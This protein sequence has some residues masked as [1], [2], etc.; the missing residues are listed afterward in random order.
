MRIIS[1]F[2]ILILIGCG[3]VSSPALTPNQP[4]ATS[5]VTATPI[6]PTVTATAT[7][8]PDVY[9]T[10]FWVTSTAIV[11]SILTAEPGRVYRSYASPDQK[12]TAEIRIYDCVRV[13][14]TTDADANAYEQLNLIENSSNI[15]RSADGQ[16]QNCGGVGAVG[17]EGLYWSSNNQYFYY[18]DA[19]RGVPD[20]SCGYWE[21]PVLRLDVGALKI[22][23]L[24]GG[25]VSPDRTKIATWQGKE[26]VVWDINMGTEI[27]RI[28]PYIL[29]TEMWM[30]PIVW[31]PDNQAFVYVQTESYC[32]PS[33]NSRVVR[34]DLPDL[35][36]TILFE[37]QTPTFG[38]AHWD[39]IHELRLFDESGK[40]WIYTFGNQKLEPLP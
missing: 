2:W 33:G 1:L 37:S 9:A 15:K 4:T 10:D 28:S 3:S 12:W 40:Q 29:N 19:G 25:P 23:E 30:G 39:E 32:P 17:L 26:I 24:G 21:R 13:N 16:L 11:N 18:T 6:N 38:S 7:V 8:T 22:E 36:Q 35:K 34:V 20:G 31:S 27:G 5:P 14:T